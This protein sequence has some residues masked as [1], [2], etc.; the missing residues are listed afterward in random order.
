MIHEGQE[1]SVFV[2]R[3]LPIDAVHG[4]REEEVAHLPPALEIDLAPLGMSV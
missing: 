3:S 2:A 4:G 1:R